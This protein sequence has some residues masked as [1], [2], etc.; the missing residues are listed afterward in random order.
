MSST[1]TWATVLD[2]LVGNG[3]FTEVV[4]NHLRLD[5]D[6][7]ELLSGVD[8]NDGTNHLWDDNHVTEMGLDEVWLLVW[9]GLLLSLAELLDQTHWLALETTVESSAGTGMDEIAELLGGEVEESVDEIRVRYCFLLALNSQFPSFPPPDTEISLLG[10]FQASSHH[11]FHPGK[12]KLAIRG[13]ILLKVDSSVG[14]LAERSLGLLLYKSISL[15][16]PKFREIGRFL[17]AASTG[18]Y[19]VSAIL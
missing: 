2:W 8:S 5:L 12:P 1:D 18:S 14:E 11:F 17:P 7:V 3:E 19:S 9:L 15:K 16:I 13:D 10:P 4:T 6:L